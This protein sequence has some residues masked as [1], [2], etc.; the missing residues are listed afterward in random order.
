V[1]LHAKHVSVGESGDEYFQVSFDSEA[2]SDDDLDLSGPDQPY[3]IIQ[4]QFEDDDGDV[5]YVETH[6]HD[7]YSGH[8]RLRLIEFTPTRLSFE[9]ARADHKYVEVTYDGL[10]A[11]HFSEVQ[12]IVHI[13]FSVQG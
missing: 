10:D 6:D 9:I 13:V 2:P 12:R 8:F 1:R 4:R 3:L 7:T 11:R 5:C